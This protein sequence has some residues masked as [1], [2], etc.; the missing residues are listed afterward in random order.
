M[1][2]DRGT[3]GSLLAEHSDIDL[4]AALLLAGENHDATPSPEAVTAPGQTPKALVPYKS[5]TY[6]LEKRQGLRRA[7]G[8]KKLKKLSNRH[9]EIISRHL[10]GESGETIAICMGCTIVTVSRVLNDPLSQDLVSV[11]YRDRQGEIDALA[12]RAIAAVRDG[13]DEKRDMRIRLGAV[14][15]FTKL[16]DSIGK[17]DDSAK[18]AE[19]VVQE[20]FA[21]LKI[22][23]KNVQINIGRKDG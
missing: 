13:L 3:F 22:E 16:K 8:A 20:I 18:T 21:G 6:E 14:D 5:P 7:N 11:I 9:L 2:N 15:K 17:E 10:Q 12:G 1:P 4:R 23:G 19:D